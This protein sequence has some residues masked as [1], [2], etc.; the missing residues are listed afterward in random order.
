MSIKADVSIAK[1]TPQMAVAH[2]IVAA[3]FKQHGYECIITSGD[4]GKHSANSLHYE[5]KALD[6][7]TRHLLPSDKAAIA[8]QVARALGDNF[9]VVLE[10]TH[11]HVEYDPK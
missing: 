7:R 9:D 4:D 6:F 1:L 10:R 3:V 2:T 11:L 8:E 5:G